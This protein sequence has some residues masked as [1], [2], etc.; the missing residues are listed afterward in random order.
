MES[1]YFLLR[2]QADERH[3]LAQPC[4]IIVAAKHRRE[5][6][7]ILPTLGDSLPF[8]I[9]R[10]P[11][12]LPTPTMKVGQNLRAYLVRRELTHDRKRDRALELVQ[13]LMRQAGARSGTD[14]AC[15]HLE[16]IAFTGTPCLENRLR[17]N[18]A[19]GISD[20][21]DNDFHFK[22]ITRC[23]FRSNRSTVFR[24]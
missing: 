24:I 5:K 21:P 12:A 8:I 2:Q 22:V 15:R 4:C 20:A 17:Y 13:R 10:N 23:H 14:T 11:R 16:L 3:R 1:P 7:A 19:K 18:H 6:L 9:S